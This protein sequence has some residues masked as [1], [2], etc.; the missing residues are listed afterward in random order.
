MII[1][2]TSEAELRTLIAEVM[3]EQLQPLFT[4]H[5]IA[6]PLPEQE[7]NLSIREAATYLKCSVQTIHAKKRNGEIPVLPFR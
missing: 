6:S 3:Q 2:Q 4:S 1:L 7:A 5:K